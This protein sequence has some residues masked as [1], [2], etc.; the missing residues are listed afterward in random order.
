MLKR[1]DGTVA[2]AR[3]AYVWVRTRNYDIERALIF[4]TGV[5]LPD[6]ITRDALAVLPDLQVLITE[7]RAG[8]LI[9]VPAARADP[10]VIPAP[11]AAPAYHA[12]ALAGFSWEPIPGPSTG[13]IPAPN[14]ASASAHENGRAPAP[15][16]A[17][18]SALEN[19]TRVIT[20]RWAR[21]TLV[22]ITGA[23]GWL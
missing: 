15:K 6:A 1:G 19:R 13:R 3:R 21:L 11:K 5:M 7:F 12:S 14:A 8:P 20:A 4:V 10:L 17:P 22:A 16:A 23:E 2:A 18:A 9:A